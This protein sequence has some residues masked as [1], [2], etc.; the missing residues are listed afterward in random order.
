[1]EKEIS[2]TGISKGLFLAVLFISFKYLRSSPL[3][4]TSDVMLVCN[5]PQ[6]SSTVNENV[7][8]I[9]ENRFSVDRSRIP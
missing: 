2:I 9:V 5:D 4:L 3:K 8:L 7:E 1:M 6:S